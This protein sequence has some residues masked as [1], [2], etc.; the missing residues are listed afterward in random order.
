MC[1]RGR[2]PWGLI[3]KPHLKRLNKI[4]MRYSK[5]NKIRI[6]AIKNKIYL[7]ENFI[8]TLNA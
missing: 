1:R 2:N 7:F 4:K 3:S 5:N 6:F 8:Q